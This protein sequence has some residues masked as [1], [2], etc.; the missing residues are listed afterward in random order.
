MEQ[1]FAI[2]NAGAAFPPWEKHSQ[3]FTSYVH[4]GASVSPEVIQKKGYGAN[5]LHSTCSGQHPA[6]FVSKELKEG[7]HTAVQLAPAACPG[8]CLCG[9]LRLCL[10]RDPPRSLQSPGRGHGVRMFF[11]VQWRTTAE[12]RVRSEKP[13]AWL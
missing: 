4:N 7:E 3:P 8:H 12:D 13:E 2:S 11:C 6:S 1:M 5:F 9:G 10:R